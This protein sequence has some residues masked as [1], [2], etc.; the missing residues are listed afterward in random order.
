MVGVVL[1]PFNRNLYSALR[2]GGAWLTKLSSDLSSSLSTDKLPLYPPR[3]LALGTSMIGL[4]IGKDRSG[5]DFKTRLGTIENLVSAEGGI[6]HGIRMRGSAALELCY[7][8]AGQL[9]GCWQRASVWDRCAGWVILS[10]AG[11]LIADG[12]PPANIGSDSINEPHLFGKYFLFVRQ[13]RVREEMEGW[14][15]DFWRQIKISS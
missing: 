4:N 7:I 13:A 15:R 11:G 9:D 6:V 5:K 1:N 14:V 8:A 2:S 10:E 12:S 3:P